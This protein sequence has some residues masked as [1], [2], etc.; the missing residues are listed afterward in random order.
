VEIKF[1]SFDPVRP[2]KNYI[3][4]I[5]F[6]ET[7]APMPS[8]DMKLVVP[9]GRLLMIIPVRNG[10]TGLMDNNYY[11]TSTNKIALVG[12]SDRPSIVDAQTQGPVASIGVEITAMGAYRF[13]HLRLKDISNQLQLLPDI[14][15]KTAATIEQRLAETPAIHGKIHLLQQFFLSLF[16]K[17]EE[18][19][20]FEY[21][22]RQIQNSNGY[23]LMKQ[24]ERE[25]GYSS[26]WLNLKF[27]ERLG[28][29]PKNYSSIVR[30]QKYYR[31]LLLNPNEFFKQ[32]SFYDYYYDESHFIKDFRRFTD[33]SPNRLVRAKNEFGKTFYKD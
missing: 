21:C 15:G 30:F 10:L 3:G 9:N 25:T 11:E 24:L 18:D 31:E 4:K 13:F 16:I 7:S 22:I 14:L 5:W 28:I 19:P 8:D 20:L 1:Q 32:K 27:E 26:R 12:M 2:L 6:F 17:K 33:I 29:S 23:N